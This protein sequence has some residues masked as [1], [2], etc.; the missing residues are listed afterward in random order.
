MIQ[1]QAPV[2]GLDVGTSRI[3]VARQAGQEIRYD[4]QLNAF[5][6]IPYTKITEG[7]L[8]REHV[9]HTVQGSE[10]LV[11]GNESEKFASLLNGLQHG[12]LF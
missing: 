5:V 11:H 12:G 4:S 2:L 10:I 1:G 3:V 8:K 9:P 7:A 6:S